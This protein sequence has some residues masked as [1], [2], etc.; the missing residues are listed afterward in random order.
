MNIFAGK[1]LEP[2]SEPIN[3]CRKED[4]PNDKSHKPRKRRKDEIFHI[5]KRQIRYAL[6]YSSEAKREAGDKNLRL[7]KSERGRRKARDGRSDISNHVAAKGEKRE[8]D[9]L[10][11]VP[12]GRGQKS[13]DDDG[14]PESNRAK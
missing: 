12:K 8:K 5:K 1:L 7:H 2:V 14:D 4:Q 11:G 10:H 13:K 6:L 3:P 9:I